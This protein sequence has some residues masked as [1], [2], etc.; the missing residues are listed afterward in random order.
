MFVL[1][2]IT[3]LVEMAT[4]SCV[5]KSMNREPGGL[6]SMGSQKSNTMA[7]SKHNAAITQNTYQQPL[8]LLECVCVCVFE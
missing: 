8:S 2:N 5:P 3:I 1:D 6:Y 4:H 7:T